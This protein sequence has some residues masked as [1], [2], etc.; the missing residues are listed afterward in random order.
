MTLQEIRQ[1]DKLFLIPTDICELLECQP[2][3]INVQAQQDPRKL[4]FPVNV[5][6]TRVRIPRVAF[7]RWLEGSG[8]W[9]E[10]Q[11][12]CEI[13]GEKTR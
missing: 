7:L 10:T 4:G 11:Q 8:M 2:Y 1:S 9:D 5:M 13:A 6:G 12:V 3:T